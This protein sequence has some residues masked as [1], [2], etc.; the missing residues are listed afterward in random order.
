MTLQTQDTE[1]FRLSLPGG[2]LS[3]SGRRGTES[4]DALRSLLD[5]STQTLVDN[6]PPVPLFFHYDDYLVDL[7]DKDSE[8]HYYGIQQP[9]VC[10]EEDDHWWDPEISYPCGLPGH[11]HKLAFCQEFWYKTPM[12]R[13][14]KLLPGSLCKHCLEPLTLCSPNGQHCSKQV[15]EGLSCSGCMRKADEWGQPPL[16]AL[17]CTKTDLDHKKQPREVIVSTAEEYFGGWNIKIGLS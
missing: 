15:P 4:L 2:S 10:A 1:S 12:D 17:F 13:H 9:R 11:M 8:H 16:N 7:P 3:L 14:Q 6:G 5:E